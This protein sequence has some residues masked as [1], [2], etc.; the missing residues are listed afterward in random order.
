MYNVDDSTSLFNSL[1]LEGKIN[2]DNIVFDVAHPGTD[3]E[4][5]ELVW[6]SSGES[7]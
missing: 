2:G 4:I 7:S 3:G 5:L 6:K 1:I